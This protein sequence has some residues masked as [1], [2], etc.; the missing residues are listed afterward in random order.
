MVMNTR[1]ATKAIIVGAGI[2]GLTAA[3]ALKQA[4][5]DVILLERAEELHEVGSG[6]PLWTNALRPLQK[7]GLT[8]VLEEIGVPVTAGS[9]TTWRGD[10]LADLR[11][12]DLL[13]RLGTIST[14]VHRAELHT[15]LLNACGS[16]NLRLGTTCIGFRQETDRVYALLADGEEVPGDLLIGADGIHSAI[17]TQVAGAKKPHY[18]GYTCWRGVAHI[19]DTELETWAWGKG[20]QFG[21]TPMTNQRAYWFAQRYAVEGE[22]DGPCG[23]KQEVFGLFHDWH[24]PIP[25]VIRATSETDILRNDVYEHQPLRH[26]SCGR[27]TLLGDAAHAMTP[28]LGQGACQAIEDAVVLGH[29]LTNEVDSV[30]AL[31]RY[32]RLRV[33]RANRIGRLARRIGQAV[34]L[35]Q[36]ALAVARNNIVKRIPTSLLLHSLLWILEYEA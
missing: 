3:L 17:R 24:D 28:N 23:R 35:E 6:L 22:Q 21:I 18:A 31:K 27:V 9:I 29:C 25:R 20:Y 14:V 12:D 26:W 33:T 32:E 16:E 13:A 8:H 30:S 2:G 10:I 19:D 11:K 15:A 34:Q 7:L 36:P 4:G 1:S 5:L